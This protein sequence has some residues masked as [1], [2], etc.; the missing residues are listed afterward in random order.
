MTY[1]FTEID[2]KILD[3]MGDNFLL[4]AEQVLA[5]KGTST[6]YWGGL[7]LEITE[8]RPKYNLEQKNDN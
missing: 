3:F 2:N 5:D 4:L 8:G 1:E 7:K 6:Y